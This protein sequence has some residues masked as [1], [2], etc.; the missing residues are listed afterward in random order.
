MSFLGNLNRVLDKSVTVVVGDNSMPEE[1]RQRADRLG[2][3]VVAT[4]WVIQSLI[5]GTKLSYHNTKFHLKYLDTT[6]K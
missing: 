5:H 6:N 1:E 4:E 3:P 2:V